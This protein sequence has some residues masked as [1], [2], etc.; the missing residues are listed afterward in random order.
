MYFSQGLK[1]S[2]GTGGTWWGIVCIPGKEKLANRKQFYNDFCGTVE[3]FGLAMH[4]R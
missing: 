4:H 1:K 2:Q 3:H